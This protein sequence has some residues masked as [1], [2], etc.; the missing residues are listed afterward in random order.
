MKEYCH[1][2]F[3]K[4]YSWQKHWD[5]K[6]LYTFKIKRVP[7]IINI[8]SKLK[9]WRWLKTNIK[10]PQQALSSY[11]GERLKL[12]ML[13]LTPKAGYIT[14]KTQP[15]HAGNVWRSTRW[16]FQLHSQQMVLIAFKTFKTY[17]ICREYSERDHKEMSLVKNTYR[18]YI[19]LRSTSFFSAATERNVE[20]NAVE[21]I[22][23]LKW[24][25]W[26]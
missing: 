7:L 26:W 19:T 20:Q 16:C 24:S 1:N 21:V 13:Y 25:K 18:S 6:R 15:R 12:I 9:N 3:R 2:T 4:L 23:V 22:W 14:D 11:A 17:F 5:E 8:W 10:K